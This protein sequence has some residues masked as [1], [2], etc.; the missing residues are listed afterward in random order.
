MQHFP[1]NANH[2]LT[3]IFDPNDK[4]VQFYFDITKTTGRTEEG[5]PYFDD[6]FLDIVLIPGRPAFVLDEDELE[7][8]LEQTVINKTDYNLAIAETDKIVH[9]IETGTNVLINK[10]LPH[11]ETMKQ[12]LLSNNG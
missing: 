12:S 9:S 3:T 11:Y 2:S 1:E 10:A 6:L 5:I 7:E 8:A 4:I